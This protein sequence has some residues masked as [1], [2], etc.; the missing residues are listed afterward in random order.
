MACGVQTIS[1]SLVLV[2]RALFGIGYPGIFLLN[3]ILVSKWF[4]EDGPNHTYLALGMSLLATAYRSGTA[5]NNLVS[6]RLSEHVS[7]QFAYWFG[8]GICVC[9]VLCSL[10]ISSMERKR[11]FNQSQVDEGRPNPQVATNSIW[12]KVRSI[13][14]NLRAYPQ[15]FWLLL[16]LIAMFYG[17]IAVSNSVSS[18]YLIGRLCNGLCCT[19]VE[20][21]CAAEQAAEDTASFMMSIPLVFGIVLGPFIGIGIDHV[22]HMTL[23]L[24]GSTC[25]FSV[26]FALFAFS[27][28]S[29]YYSL[30]AEGLSIAVFAC[31]SWPCVPRV[32]EKSMIGVAFGLIACAYSL[33]LTLMPIFVSVFQESYSSY[34]SVQILFFVLSCSMFILSIYLWG[35]DYSNGRVFQEK[36]TQSQ[37]RSTSRDTITSKGT[38]V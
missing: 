32:V 1:P 33:A 35:L 15:M 2:S 22:G 31:A 3:C 38:E 37:E 26:A 16:T 36:S 25:L 20:T 34:E 14:Q 8:V 6:P 24:V 7:V 19:D 17:V 9:R 30:V 5:I 21:T 29:V 12:Q 10:Y 11:L 13:C 23:L 4:E 18:A 28:I 27:N